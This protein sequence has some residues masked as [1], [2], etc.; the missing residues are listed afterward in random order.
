MYQ[1]QAILKLIKIN[2]IKNMIPL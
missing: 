2:E 1:M